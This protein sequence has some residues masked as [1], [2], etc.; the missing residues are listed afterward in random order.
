[1]TATYAGHRFSSHLA[2][3]WAVFFDALN[4]AWRYAPPSLTLP[5]GT[6]YAADFHLPDL[7]LW[8]VVEDDEDEFVRNGQIHAE[9]AYHLRTG[10]LILGPIPQPTYR[11]PQH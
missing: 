9:A 5:S 2:A 10:L 11:V 8:V 3:Q 4:I 1:M 7:D 6:P